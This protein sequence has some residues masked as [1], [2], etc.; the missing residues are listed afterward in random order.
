MNKDELTNVI[1]RRQRSGIGKI[2]VFKPRSGGRK[3]AAR[4]SEESPKLVMFEAAGSSL[5][6]LRIED[7]DTIVCKRTFKVSEIDGK[8]CVVRIV[9][10][11]EKKARIVAR[12]PGGSV[13]IST[14]DP[15]TPRET[16]GADEIEILAIAV[17][18]RH[19]L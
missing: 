13:T 1:S 9:A 6:G 3:P 18:V 5:R 16:F 8:V 2:L 11:G 17:E 10:T 14:T 15:E 7:G 19:K 4:P 12:N